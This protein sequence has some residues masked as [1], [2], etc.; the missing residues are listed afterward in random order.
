MFFHLLLTTDC[1]LKCRYCYEKS[2]D[3]I[4]SDFGN[5]NIDYDVPSKISYDL[6]HLAKFIK[7]DPEPILIFYGGEPML[8]TNKIQ[9]IID[10]VPAK[11][12]NIQTNG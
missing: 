6:D 8:Y 11:Q 7:K 2:C 1:D 5:F 4:D 10:N 9:Q 12:Y 3:D